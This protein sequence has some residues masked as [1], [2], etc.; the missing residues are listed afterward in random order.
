MSVSTSPTTVSL[1]GIRPFRNSAETFHRI[2]V[3]PETKDRFR[4]N[5][6]RCKLAFSARIC[7]APGA[8]LALS[9]PRFGLT[10]NL[11]QRVIKSA[12][13]RG[14]ARATDLFLFQDISNSGPTTRGNK[15]GTTI[16]KSLRLLILSSQPPVRSCRSTRPILPSRAVESFAFPD[17]GSFASGGATSQTF[18]DPRA[19][20]DAIVASLL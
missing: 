11:H 13:S 12:F 18:T 4:I 6:R 10:A 20:R 1:S 2:D 17:A 16:K 8:G 3:T 9:A 19:L 7:P 14:L 15:P 5:Q